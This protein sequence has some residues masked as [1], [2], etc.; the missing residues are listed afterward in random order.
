MAVK[1]TR[2][3]VVPDQVIT[4]KNGHSLT[5]DAWLCLSNRAIELWEGA[6][7]I[8][9]TKPRKIQNINLVRVKVNVQGEY[10]VFYCDL[11][12][13]CEFESKI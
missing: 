3:D 11:L 6:S 9:M 4:V 2:K 12:T 1:L 8:I 10:E 5:L 7:L 13:H